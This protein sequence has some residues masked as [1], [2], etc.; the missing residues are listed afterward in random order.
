M[1]SERSCLYVLF[2]QCT[3]VHI[4]A[5]LREVKKHSIGEINANL[6]QFYLCLLRGNSCFRRKSVPTFGRFLLF[7]F[8]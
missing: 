4:K 3:A 1:K 6:R 7:S 2:V 8:H 5:K